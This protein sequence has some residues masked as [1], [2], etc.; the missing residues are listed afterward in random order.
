MSD[1]KFNVEVAMEV[2]VSPQVAA[3]SRSILG[4]LRSLLGVIEAKY[5]QNLMGSGL[6]ICENSDEN[7]LSLKGRID[8]YALVG[9]FREWDNDKAR[10]PVLLACYMIASY[11][12]E[13]PLA[14]LAKSDFE[15]GSFAKAV[16]EQVNGILGAVQTL[17]STL[18]PLKDLVELIL[19]KKSPWSAIAPPK[20]VEALYKV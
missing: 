11:A 19:Q 10:V 8:N 12:L 6:P 20:P 17:P 13:E 4:L 5:R 7:L 15:K 2:V 3:Q 14:F 18:A 16:C 1:L 9:F